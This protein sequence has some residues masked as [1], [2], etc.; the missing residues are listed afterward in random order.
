[1]A[2]EAYDDGDADEEPEPDTTIFVKNLGWDSPKITWNN[3][4]QIAA[5]NR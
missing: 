5:L 2:A 1:V 4:R 3:S